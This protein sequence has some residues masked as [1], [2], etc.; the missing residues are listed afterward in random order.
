VDETPLKNLK[1]KKT[2][3]KQNE[4]ALVNTLPKNIEEQE[5]IF[6]ESGCTINPVFEYENLE[7]TQKFL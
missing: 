3:V 7:L 6:F 5:L 4:Q 2:K 1:K